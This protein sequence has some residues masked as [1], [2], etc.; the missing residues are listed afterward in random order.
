MFCVESGI[1]RQSGSWQK[2][3]MILFSHTEVQRD[4]QTS[5]KIHW[6]RSLALVYID[7]EV[8]NENSR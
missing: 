7:E 5:D 3:D 2:V 1:I 8:F 4:G 6:I